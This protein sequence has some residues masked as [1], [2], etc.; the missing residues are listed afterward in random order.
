MAMN[1]KDA[2]SSIQEYFRSMT[3]IPPTELLHFISHL[4]LKKVEKDDFLYRQ[5][6]HFGEIGFV[7]KG[8][9]YNFY[10]KVD[11][12]INV[13]YFIHEGMPVTCYANLLTQT[14]ASFSCKAIENS[15]ILVIQY[16]DFKNLYHRHSC[17]EK[18]GRLSAEGLYIEK[19]NRE[20]EFFL[21]GEERYSFF[22]KKYSKLVNRVPQYLIA[23]YIGITPESLSRIRKKLTQK[24]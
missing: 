7:V 9:L 2:V 13:N 20:T 10:T 19:E 8:L 17:W 18:L 3:Y 15:Y 23:S 12:S 11:G 16:K 21:G 6:E 1:F 5:N 4:S 22:V 14:P 24:A